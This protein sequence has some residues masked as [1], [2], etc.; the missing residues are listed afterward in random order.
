MSLLVEVR[1]QPR[2]V[3]GELIG[4]GEPCRLPNSLA[5][6]LESTGLVAWPS[7]KVALKAARDR[8]EKRKKSAEAKAAADKK[9]KR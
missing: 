7:E 1:K 4:I 5:K 8:A 9:G 2:I 6:A 3:D